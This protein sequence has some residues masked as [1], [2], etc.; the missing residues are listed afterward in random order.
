MATTIA[1]TEPRG[2]NYG[3]FADAAG[4]IATLV[5]AIV[6]LAGVHSG[7]LVA[8][9]TIVFGAALLIQGG[10]MLSEYAHIIFP[11]G[12]SAVATT[13]FSDGGL[14]ALFLVGGAGIVLGILALL[15]IYPVE[16]TAIAAIAFGGAL[17]ASGNAVWHLH[18][19][20]RASMKARDPQDTR[21][22]SEILAGEMAS[23]SAAIQALA[24]LTAV[25]LGILAVV[26]TNPGVLTM[27]ALLVLGATIV[28]T[29][30]TL[31]G[32]ALSLMRPSA[33]A[34]RAPVGGV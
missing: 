16:L 32:A 25:I 26:G 22:G 33:H 8:V 11:P 14:S 9:A 34:A 31:S 20:K 21:Y 2:M 7:S 4:G 27:T 17:V 30:S 19:L 28:L 15:G 5:L 10:T 23:G 24:G 12:E 18:V 13:E 29:G 6:A 1:E 3:G